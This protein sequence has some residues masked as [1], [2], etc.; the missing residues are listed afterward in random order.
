MSY[1]VLAR[2]WRPR[3]FKEMVGQTHVLRALINALDN[4]RLHHAFLFTGT[5]GVGKTTISRILAKSLNC[6]QGVSSTPCGTCGS[7]REIDEGRFVDLIE[8]DAASR[9]K[10]E[11]T[12]EL[13]ENVQYAPTR[14][15]YKVYLIDEVHMLS[16]H[17]FNALLKTLEEPPPHVK[18]L[19]ATTD[20]KKLPVTILSRCLQFSLRRISVELISNHLKH[21]LEQEQIPF[22]VEALKLI[23]HGA[24]GS[25]RDALSLLEQA[26]AFGGGEV[27]ESETRSMLGTIDRHYIFNLLQ[28][29][30]QQ[31]GTA[32]M[33]AVEELSAQAPDYQAVCAELLTA[34]QRIAMAQMVPDALSDEDAHQVL[35]LLA[36]QMT[37][38]TVQLYYQI[39]LHMRRDLPLAP[40][41]RGGLEMGLLRM[42]AFNP[43]TT[44][45]GTPP[46]NTP[47]GREPPT[48]T[49]PNREKDSP[50]QEAL[51]SV[52]KPLDPTDQASRKEATAAH[53]SAAKTEA[54]VA[55]SAHASAMAAVRNTLTSKPPAGQRV[56]R[57]R[58]GLAKTPPPVNTEQAPIITAKSAEA[59]QPEATSAATE[60]PHPANW[61][62]VV[63]QLK[64]GG[65]TRQL[66]M[67]CTLASHKNNLI[68]LCLIQSHEQFINREREDQLQQALSSHFNREIKLQ[69]SIGESETENPMQI[70]Q[71]R[72]AQKQQ[73][74]EQSI[75][76]D[77]AIHAMQQRFSAEII[78]DSIRPTGS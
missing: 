57:T 44:L 16:T 14:G 53:N 42:L 73:A 9:T 49:P 58:A 54:A 68:E 37:P 47:S 26:I 13:L 12:R 77:P 50:A 28:S 78:A 15:R 74:A 4:N 33:A 56:G 43:A 32:V 5:R 60:T 21:L 24:D 23:A 41:P 48:L 25:M 66:A 46:P 75:Q 27:K 51:A 19:L 40:D 55:N 64:I 20:P 11:D 34:L 61:D 22:Q 67:H 2:K 10:V 62:K 69:I 45:P 29:L 7:C 38:E 30:A 63:A 3:N 72:L 59:P 70:Q 35:A 18:F 52:K 71:R 39:A 31:D 8:V 6:D 1:Q 36:T 17:S 76:N 65:L